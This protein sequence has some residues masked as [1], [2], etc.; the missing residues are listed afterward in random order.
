MKTPAMS[1]S[2]CAATTVISSELAVE[3]LALPS[4]PVGEFVAP[5]N[6]DL[7]FGSSTPVTPAELTA[8]PWR[9]DLARGH[10]DHHVAH[11]HTTPDEVDYWVMW[12][13]DELPDLVRAA[14]CSS[15]HSGVDS[16]LCLLPAGHTGSH[17][18]GERRWVEADGTALP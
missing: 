8:T 18:G 11:A 4:H 16:E 1:H 14:V 15:R 3:I 12:V 13:D 7:M 6:S 2:G 9:C 17:D 10:T 5:G